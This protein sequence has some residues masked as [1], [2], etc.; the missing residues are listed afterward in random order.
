[1]VYRGLGS[2]IVRAKKDGA[3]IE[4]RNDEV[5]NQFITTIWRQKL[6]EKSASLDEKGPSNGEKSASFR[7]KRQS[8][9]EKVITDLLD[10]CCVPRSM[11]EIVGHLKIKDRNYLKD[12]YINPLLGKRMFMTKPEAPTSPNQKYYTI[13]KH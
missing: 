5:T 2:G 12:N 13:Q 9:K 8:K 7:V 1:M 11:A 10:F 6:D 4:F 3:E